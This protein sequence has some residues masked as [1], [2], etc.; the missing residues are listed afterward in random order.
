[1]ML[2][3][4]DFVLLLLLNFFPGNKI[5]FIEWRLSSWVL[6]GETVEYVLV[7]LTISSL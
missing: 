4:D 7:L 5:D 3:I 6:I 2:C 1:M